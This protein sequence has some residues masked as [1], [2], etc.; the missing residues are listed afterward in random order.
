MATKQYKI[1][2]DDKLIGTTEFE[3][4]DHRWELSLDKFT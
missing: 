3:K 4:A 2:L 1:F